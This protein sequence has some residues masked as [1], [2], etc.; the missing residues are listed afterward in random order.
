[1]PLFGA[2]AEGYWEDVGTLEAYVRVHKDA[3]DGKVEIDIPGFR[4]EHGVWL[5]EGAE[6]HP[7]AVVEGPAVIGEN[8]RVE[9]DARIGEYTVLGDNV[10]VREGA[11]LERVVI[12]DNA[13]LGPEHSPAG[14]GG[15]AGL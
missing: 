5:G 9:R 6:I 7:E 8:C 12:H 10:R 2:V 4:L 15:R 11:D 3:L 14:H 1:M 13:Y